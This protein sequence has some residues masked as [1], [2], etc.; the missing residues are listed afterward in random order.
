[1][2]VKLCSV[3]FSNDQRLS[4]LIIA[5]SA[6]KVAEFLLCNNTDYGCLSS[7]TVIFI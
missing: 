4:V 6:L 2:S 1:M 7:E 5:V 3:I